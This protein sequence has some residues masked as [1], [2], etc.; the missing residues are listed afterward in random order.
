MMTQ[1]SVV[2][3]VDG[4][5]DGELGFAG[6]GEDELLL[7]ELDEVGAGNGPVSVGA[8]PVA[9]PAAHDSTFDTYSIEL[10]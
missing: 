3:V 6:D 8:A 10:L 1:A 4:G 7:D 5:A 9:Y 2:V